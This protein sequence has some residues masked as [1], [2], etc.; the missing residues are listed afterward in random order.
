MP[1]LRLEEAFF[2]DGEPEKETVERLFTGYTFYK[3]TALLKEQ[4]KAEID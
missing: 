3:K 4:I 2:E 1:V